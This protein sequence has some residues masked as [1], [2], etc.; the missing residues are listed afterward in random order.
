MEDSRPDRF[1]VAV[2]W[3][4]ELGWEKDLFSQKLFKRFVNQASI[5]M[6]A[7]ADSDLASVSG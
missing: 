4:P 7:Q 3:H 1:V 5:V 6:P 2:Q